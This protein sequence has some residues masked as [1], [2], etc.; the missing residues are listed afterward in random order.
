M[1]LPS[2]LLFKI[3]KYIILKSNI[4]G[5]GMIKIESIISNSKEEFNKTVS[6]Y[7]NSEIAARI[8]LDLKNREVFAGVYNTLNE[9]TEFN[10]DYVILFSKENT[11][12]EKI[13]NE[14]VLRAANKIL[15]TCLLYTSDAADE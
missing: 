5:E 1:N 4:D 2:S 3:I 9:F 7:N 6:L 13:S 14:D 10:D 12:K 15:N 11:P 8:Y